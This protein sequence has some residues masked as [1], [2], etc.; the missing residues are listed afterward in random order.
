MMCS[1]L[2]SIRA[3][4]LLLL[5]P[6][7][8]MPFFSVVIPLFNKE[9][10]V[11]RTI[12]SILAQTFT[13]Y[14]IIVVNDSST[15]A[16]AAIVKTFGEKVRIVE[17]VVNKGLSASRNTGIE[18]ASA[19][20]IAFLDADDLWKPYFLEKIFE[21]IQKFPDA[22]LFATAY[23]ERYQNRAVSVRKN[24]NFAPDEMNLVQD[25]FDANSHQPLFCYSSVVVKKD[26]FVTAGNF[27]ETITLGEDVDFNIRAFQHFELAYFNNSAAEYTIFSENQITN[28]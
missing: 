9:T 18:H 4:I 8:I 1:R 22:G 13:D 5:K 15:D 7:A 3:K 24:V 11:A 23:D 14:E 19:D 12:E 2:S 17:H 26:V 28:S 25:V 10:F 21:L 20:F 16:S 27:D 6:E